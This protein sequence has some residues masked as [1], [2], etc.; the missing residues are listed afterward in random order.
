MAT[1]TNYGWTTPDD[2]ALVKDGAAAIRTLGSS[3]DTSVKSLN[4]GTTAGD[5]DYYTSATAKTRVAI[6]TSGQ[7]L[8]VVG[9]VPAWAASPTSVLTAKG[10]VLTATAANTIARIGVGANDTVLTADS[11]AA[12][13]LKWAAPAAGGMI[14]I[15]SGSLTGTSV[16]ISSIAQTYKHLYLYIFNPAFATTATQPVFRINGV[17]TGYALNA[18]RASSATL[19]AVTAQTYLEPSA[20]NGNT[21]TTTSNQQFGIEIKNYATTTWKPINMF[22]IDNTA[23]SAN[24]AVGFFNSSAA[25]TSLTIG[26]VNG[27]SSYNGGT[28][29]LY[30]VN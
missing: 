13:G 10:D 1:T 4:A 28:Y 27:T 24:Y 16:V 7:S 25:V 19:T 15:A 17:T 20:G 23:T 12:T 30:G 18:Q 21:F 2:T 9:G 29:I 6:G 11:T 3:I 14:S 26:S 8:T 22:S 5:L